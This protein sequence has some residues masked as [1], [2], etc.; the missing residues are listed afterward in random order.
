[1]QV[2]TSQRVAPAHPP[3]VPPRPSRQMPPITVN[4]TN[5]ING[6]DLV[7]RRPR[8]A[9][10]P[11]P[12]RQ[13]PAP[14]V[15]QRPW[16]KQPPPQPIQ[17]PRPRASSCSS[18]SSSSGRTVIY[19]SINHPQQII[20][21]SK[22]NQN[23]RLAPPT[24]PPPTKPRSELEV[25]L[26]NG[27]KLSTFN[28]VEELI[29]DT[30]KRKAGDGCAN[31]QN[32]N[33]NN[34]N[35]VKENDNICNGQ[36]D[37]EVKEGLDTTKKNNNKDL[38]VKFE[39][40]S[41]A[42]KDKDTNSA[43]ELSSPECATVV[44]IE[45]R[46]DVPEGCSPSDSE[47]NPTLLQKHQQQLDNIRT[48][49]WLEAGVRYTSTKITLPAEQPELL[50]HQNQRYYP[51]QQNEFADLDFSSIIKRIAMSSLQGLPPLPRSLSGF[52]LNGVGLTSDSPV[53]VANS[54]INANNNAQTSSR[55]SSRSQ[56]GPKTPS[57]TSLSSG[58][59][60]SIR[61][62]PQG[63]QLTTLDTQLAILRREMVRLFL[64]LGV[65]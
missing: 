57:T 59:Q 18:S 31:P 4:N 48:Q 13:A 17:Q 23:Q 38:C 32:D 34:H 64:D 22:S 50:N 2:A 65:I 36:K 19:E 29:D 10:P 25:A 20:S 47:T 51:K 16:P 11:C 49:D 54:G 61:P 33:N 24:T 44:I 56:R 39:E 43:S 27:L 7:S 63:R 45:D 55:S 60:G 58:S 41:V 30:S 12:T 3:P 62:S 52:N 15:N 35:E 8:P 6:N 28:G 40:E 53:H 46:E 1:M 37:D 14:P 21:T 26:V 5:G 9:P 42:D